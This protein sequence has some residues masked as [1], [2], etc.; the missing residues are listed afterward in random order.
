MHFCTSSYFFVSILKAALPERCGT[1]SGHEVESN[2][3]FITSEGNKRLCSNDAS[4]QSA[5]RFRK[6]SKAP[7]FF[8]RLPEVRPVWSKPLRDNIQEKYRGLCGWTQKGFPG[9]HPARMHRGNYERILQ[10]PYMVTWKSVG[11][12]YMMLIKGKDELYMLDQGDYLFSVDHIQFPFDAEYTSHLEDTLVDGEFVIDNVDGL[13]KPT[14]WISDIITYNGQDVSKKP[15]P[16]RLKLISQSIVTIRDNAIRKG[17]IKKTT[18]PFLIRKKEF[19]GLSEANKLFRPKSLANI[20]HK[21]EALFFLPEKDP[22]TPGECQDV[23]KWKENEMIEFRL[24]IIP[25]ASNRGALPE[26]NAHLFLCCKKVDTLYD[27]MP[28]SPDL[29]QYDNE[30]IS[31]S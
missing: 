4:D 2:D 7:E 27:T 19:V 8:V 21:V 9:S 29:E 3:D 26:K 12:R 14:L 18:Q 11:K 22:Y 23:L 20:P 30:I 28:Y 24:K 6:S 13:F 10:S 17:H 15:L 31:C 5:K 1:S 16:D 25:N